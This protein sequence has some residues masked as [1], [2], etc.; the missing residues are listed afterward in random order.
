MTQTY[1][2]IVLIILRQ[3]DK[4]R[5]LIEPWI[6]CYDALLQ[7]YQNNGISLLITLW[8]SKSSF[9]IIY[10]RISPYYLDIAITITKHEVK[11]KIKASN[12][13]KKKKA[14]KQHYVMIFEE[15]DLVWIFLKKK[16][17]P[18]E[19]YNKFKEKKIGPC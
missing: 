4:L 11:K 16:Y 1:Y 15:G 13:V 9:H 10:D 2:I 18:V 14:K 12:Q 19:T 5:L 8:L 3:M 6:I 7:K 17:F